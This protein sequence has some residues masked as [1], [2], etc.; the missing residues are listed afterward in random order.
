[1]GHGTLWG[2][3]W[4]TPAPPPGPRMVTWSSSWSALW[5][6]GHCWDCEAS[7]WSRRITWLEYW[8]LIGW[9][10]PLP[11]DIQSVVKKMESYN[12]NEASK[13][14]GSETKQWNLLWNKLRI[15]NLTELLLNVGWWQRKNVVKQRLSFWE[16]WNENCNKWPVGL[17]ISSIYSNFVVVLEYLGCENEHAN[18]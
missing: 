14:N 13:Y 15:W 5:S 18:G 6:P 10:T 2:T 9:D 16:F 11:C 4:W 12:V 17:N 7:D 1:M 3:S 8:P